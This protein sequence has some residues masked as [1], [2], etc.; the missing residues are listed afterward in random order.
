MKITRQGV[1]SFWAGACAITLAFGAGATGTDNRVNLKAPTEAPGLADTNF[2]LEPPAFAH[3]D[4]LLALDLNR[5][6]VVNKILAKFE[7]EQPAE[8]L[9]GLRGKLFELRADQLL[10][11]SL[12]GS[13]DSVVDIIAAAAEAAKNR[14]AVTTTRTASGAASAVGTDSR[15]VLGDPNA[16]LVYTP[17]TPCR[18]ID[19]RGFPSALGTIGGV[20]PPNTRRAVAPAGGCGIPGAN[21]K[22]LVMG[23]TT[24]N[25][26][27]SSGGY[28][29]IVA[30]AAAI[31]AT[32]DIFNVGGEWSASNII[33]TTG[34]AGQFDVFVSGA[35]AHF[36]ADVVGYFAAP[37][38][39]AASF[40]QNTTVLQP[41]SNFNISGTGLIG[42]N[43]GVGTATPGSK[44]DVLQGGVTIGGVNVDR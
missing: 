3:P 29:A 30:P 20:F 38:G 13:V 23:F 39:L 12:A 28:L 16:D 33:T 22:A 43:L 2:A 14:T 35:T 9:K 15:K 19:T 5:S 32:V 41:S 44:L 26:T 10:A 7:T 18:L 21:V 36:V 24:Q 34:T 31:S 4:A 40:I 11:A 42:G 27:P 37:T 8:R 6:A 17:L 1:Y 25:L